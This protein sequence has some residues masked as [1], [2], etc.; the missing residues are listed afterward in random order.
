MNEVKDIEVGGDE[1]EMIIL[2]NNNK[3]I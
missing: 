1:I 3:T 2:Y